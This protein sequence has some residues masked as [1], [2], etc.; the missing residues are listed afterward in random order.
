MRPSD[1]R[2]NLFNHHHR[3]GDEN[4]GSFRFDPTDPTLMRTTSGI[5]IPESDYCHYVSGTRHPMLSELRAATMD[6]GPGSIV[7]P[8]T[9]PLL[10][11]NLRDRLSRGAVYGIDLVWQSEQRAMH[12]MVIGP[13]GAGK[14]TTV[15]DPLR[16]SAIAD[17]AQTV[18]SFS[19]KAG[20][21]GPIK[22]LCKK[23]KKRL[24]VINLNDAQRSLSWNPLDVDSLDEAIDV[25]RRYTDSVKNPHSDDS[26]FW[27]QWIRTGFAGAWQAGYRSFPELYQFFAL[28]TDELIRALKTHNNPSSQ[29]LAA[30]LEGRSHNAETVLASIVG[31]MASFLSDSV[32]RVMGSSELKLQRLFR[33]PVCLHV[34]I[35]EA[36]LETLLVLYQMFARAVTDELIDSAERNHRKVIP[37][38]MFFDDLPSLGRILTPSRLMTMRSRG[39][40]TVS[41][42]QSLS[43]LESIYGGAS[44]ALIDNVHTK[45]ILPGGVASDA[46]YFSQA[47]GL[48]MVALPTYENQAPSFVQRP[49]LSGA[50]IRT[51]GY[52]HPIFGMPATFIVGATSFQAYLQR[53]YEH[54]AIADLLRAGKR[55]SGRERIRKSPLPLPPRIAKTEP[56]V[57]TGTALPPG[58]TN[59]A[60]WTSTQLTELLEQIKKNSLDWPNTVGSARKWWSAFEEEN[61]TRL[62]LVV[63]LAEELQVR[64]ATIT[65][66]FLS[67]V[68]SNTDNIQA[69][70]S[71]LDYTR[72]KKEEES[73]KKEA[74]ARK[75]KENGGE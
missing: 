66:F 69:N 44:R 73:K 24:V 54:P 29:Q 38:T 59:T 35:S 28:P 34:E 3:P 42:V 32:V 14:N 31:A 71:Y 56:N 62:A 52:H 67:Y 68:Y 22:S 39:I 19:L 36:R 63:R 12:T 50:N 7:L 4:Q 23:F 17:P 40:G 47:T 49:V 27:S 74:A 20:D 43:S 16:Y 37:S 6:A 72:L 9:I 2:S 11:E 61:K 15:I 70:L 5:E 75:L 51:P 8:C 45:I 30:F 21:F 55:A 33:K 65:E 26:E 10:N 48:Q 46:E 64:R 41:G 1:D 18:I 25:I 13:T 60:G 53:S 58:I 57:G